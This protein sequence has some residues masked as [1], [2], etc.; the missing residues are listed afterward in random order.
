MSALLLRAQRKP[1]EDANRYLTISLEPS[2]RAALRAH[3][4]QLRR[5]AGAR[6]DR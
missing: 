2:D 1:D 5:H 6:P 4:E 3:I